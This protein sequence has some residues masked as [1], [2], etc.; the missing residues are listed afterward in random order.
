MAA[1]GLLFLLFASC[2]ALL[3]SPMT[4]PSLR[5]HRQS[6]VIQQG[7][8]DNINEP[9][10]ILPY[11]GIAAFVG[12]RGKKAYKKFVIR[13]DRLVEEYGGAIES[14]TTK[15]TRKSTFLQT[16]N[17]YRRKLLFMRKDQM[18]SRSV[19]KIVRQ[20]VSLANVDVLADLFEVSKVKKID[21]AIERI[22][23]DEV[24]KANERGRLLYYAG[25]LGVETPQLKAMCLK[26]YKGDATF[27]KATQDTIA[28]TAFIDLVKKDEGLDVEAVSQKCGV[29]LEKANA[30]Y[31]ELTK[32]PEPEEPAEKKEE[33]LQELEDAVQAESEEVVEMASDNLD[34][35]D[36][37]GNTKVDDDAK[38]E[39]DGKMITVECGSCGYTR[40]IAK[41]REF[42]FFG[43]GFTCPNCGAPKDQFAVSEVSDEA[44]ADASA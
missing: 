38:E 34:K 23:S 29:T 43:P 6:L 9:A 18:L 12:W 28:E 3:Y 30:I 20:R 22:A 41:N 16:R 2:E 35:V 44:I 39:D 40:F 19:S 8:L 14:A 26:N 17:A 11:V 25:R 37:L 21:A 7:L 15:K 5:S 24:D 10:D 13:Q 27:L 32:P 4:S 1:S 36:A 33:W 42:K 31:A